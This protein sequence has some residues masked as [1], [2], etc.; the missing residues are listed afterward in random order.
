VPLV[1]CTKKSFKI[2]LKDFKNMAIRSHIQPQKYLKGFLA[3]KETEE[4]NDKL[5]RYKKGMPFIT[6]HKNDPD[7]NPAR[8]TTKSVAYV[9]NFYAFIND[10][11][12]RDPK[13][14]EDK[15]ERE[16]ENPGNEV[17]K[18]L[19]DLKIKR[20][21]SIST[22][23]FLNDD[24]QWNFARYVSGMITRTKIARENHNNAVQKVVADTDTDGISFSEATKGVPQEEKERILSDLRSKDPA[25]DED[26]GR[27]CLPPKFKDKFI[28]ANI[29]GEAYPKGIF[30]GIELLAPFILK[31]NWQFRA[32]LPEIALPTGDEPVG[33]SDLESENATLVFPIS[34]NLVFCAYKQPADEIIYVEENPAIV[35]DLFK[36]LASKC[37][38][39]YFS[40]C[41]ANIVKLFNGE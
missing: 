5:F 13:T 20:G 19:R 15:L 37:Q 2:E 3:E 41:D 18:K 23:D 12:V 1:I 31:M 25:F 35:A 21:E 32:T 14:Y 8:L 7:N 34:S 33:Y 11:G 29:K 27:F 6:D 9:T 40:K 38:E 36:T 17:L 28:D 24:D 30:E 39:L 22:R 4:E 10:K 26:T 16:I